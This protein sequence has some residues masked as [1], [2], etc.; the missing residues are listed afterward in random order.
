MTDFDVEFD[1]CSV[2]KEDKKILCLD[3][4]VADVKK[5][6]IAVKRITEKGNHVAFGPR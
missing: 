4:Q 6:S 2:E 5:P 1:A 3:F